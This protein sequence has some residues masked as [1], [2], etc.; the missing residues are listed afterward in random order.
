MS[1]PCCANCV[2]VH[3]GYQG[4]IVSAR[5]L[6]HVPPGL[7]HAVIA[8]RVVVSLLGL[9]DVRCTR[10]LFKDVQAKLKSQDSYT[11]PNFIFSCSWSILSLCRVGLWI[12]SG[13]DGLG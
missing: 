6:A 3:V 13:G 7:Q 2:D 10:G 4:K 12:C 9:S 5:R 11:I 8:V 1:N